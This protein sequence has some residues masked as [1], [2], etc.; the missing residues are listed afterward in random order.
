[1]LHG[2]LELAEARAA[3]FDD[4]DIRNFGEPLRGHLRVRHGGP[5]QMDLK[6]SLRIAQLF[7]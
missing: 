2:F 1:M 6:L 4:A 3:L 5:S 7:W